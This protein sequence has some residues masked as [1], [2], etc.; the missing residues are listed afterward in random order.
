MDLEAILRDAALLGLAA[1]VL[2]MAAVLL[3]EM[4]AYLLKPTATVAAT[5]AKPPFGFCLP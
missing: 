5:V 4:G 3:W 1:G 2:V